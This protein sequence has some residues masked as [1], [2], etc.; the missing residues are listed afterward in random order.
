M[1]KTARMSKNKVKLFESI[2]VDINIPPIKFIGNMAENFYIL[3]Q[4]E[5]SFL[6]ELWD[7]F[8]R[9]F[10]TLSIKDQLYLETFLGIAQLNF[11]NETNLLIQRYAEGAEFKLSQLNKLIKL[12]NLLP[13]LSFPYYLFAILLPRKIV[14]LKD[15]EVVF[16]C[17]GE[18]F[19]GEHHLGILCLA[20]DPAKPE[21]F[22][23]KGMP[24]IPLAYRFN[25]TD[26]LVPILINE[27]FIPNKDESIIRW[28]QFD[29]FL[30]L[31]STLH[32]RY[33]VK[34]FLNRPVTPIGKFQVLVKQRNELEVISL[35]EHSFSKKRVHPSVSHH[36]EINE[37]KLFHGD[38]FEN[39]HPFFSSKNELQIDNTF[40]FTNDLNQITF[41]KKEI[42]NDHLL[43]MKEAIKANDLET[44]L[45]LTQINSQFSQI[46]SDQLLLTRLV[47]IYLKSNDNRIYR[48][49]LDEFTLLGDRTKDNYIKEQADLY[50]IRLMK[51]L[52]ITVKLL[53]KNLSSQLTYYYNVDIALSGKEIIAR[54]KQIFIHPNSFEVMY[55]R[56]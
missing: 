12:F 49:L 46:Y 24:F 18:L 47:V 48:F 28:N 11:S 27:F 44:I 33:H 38:E 52:G 40:E 32:K 37:H 8:E 17:E 1:R 9:I 21:I 14:K 31:I 51:I 3:G 6:S 7:N 30:E 53:R 42:I 39:L 13:T 36:E 19:K 56:K 10:K 54:K 35:F 15:K 20:Q 25:E 45:H 55:Y 23:I 29:Y 2:K 43:R 34:K 26:L 22:Y 5:K 50:K 41:I 16:T 4:R